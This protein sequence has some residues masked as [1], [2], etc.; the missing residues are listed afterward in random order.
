MALELEVEAVVTSL[1]L[2]LPL[3]EIQFMLKVKETQ[4]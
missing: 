4:M 1:V 2:M 3:T